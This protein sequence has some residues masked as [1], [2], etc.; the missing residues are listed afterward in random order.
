MPSISE[1]PA[2]WSGSRRAALA[3]VAAVTLRPGSLDAQTAAAVPPLRT[4]TLGTCRL[5]SGASLPSCRIAYRTYGTLS[6]RR[7][8]VVLIPTFFGGRSEDHAFMIGTYVDST[9]HHIVI[10]DALADGASS[11]PSNAPAASDAFGALTI[12]DMVDAQ[13]RALTEVLGIQHVRAVVGISMGGF[14]AFEW[15]VRYPT[16][17]DVAVPIVGTPRPT[18]YDRLIF[19]TW[20]RSAEELSAPHVNPDSAWTQASRLESLFMRSVRFVVD[21][22]EAHL[23][24]S[25]RE[26][27]A[28]YRGASWS[29]ADYATQLRAIGSHDVSAGFGGDMKRAGSAVR[30]RMLIVWSPDDMLV[31]PRPPATFAQ[32]VGA[33]TLAVPSACGHAVFWCEAESI[34]RRVRAFIDTAPSLA[35]R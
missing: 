7:D 17:M 29:L 3:I 4:A 27:A 34:G 26:M 2:R 23:A 1:F 8:N 21:S 28:A 11:S 35:A 15:A 33:D 19:D 32:L 22:G 20:R 31:D 30:A 16:F 12:G 24:R 25:V 14:Q 5:A 13:H 6:P 18:A 10:I 9:R